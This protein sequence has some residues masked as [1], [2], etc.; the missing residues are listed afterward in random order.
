[1]VV[2]GSFFY[3]HFADE[4]QLA[5]ADAPHDPEL[6]KRVRAGGWIADWKTLPFEMGPGLLV[7]YLANSSLFDFALS[8]SEI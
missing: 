6:G 2:V 3:L 8:A 1:M 5:F 7:D 4:P